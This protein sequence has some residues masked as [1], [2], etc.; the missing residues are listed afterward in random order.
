MK[1]ITALRFPELKVTDHL[2]WSGKGLKTSV[3]FGFQPSLE[4]PLKFYSKENNSEKHED[5]DN[6]GRRIYWI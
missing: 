5:G 1:S 3:K 2:T 6:R 4:V